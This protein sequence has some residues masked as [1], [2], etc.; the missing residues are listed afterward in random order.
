M[1]RN[2]ILLKAF[3]TFFILEMLVSTV[4]PTVSY[5]LTAGPTAPEAT[6]FEPVDTTDMVNLA[7]GDFV[8]NMPLLEVPGPGG[9][10]PLSL[11]YHAGIQPNEDASWV[12]LGWTL[13]PGAI[14]RGVNGYADDFDG[15]TGSVRTFWEG[16]ESKSYSI[17]INYG[18]AQN[19]SIS[20]GL[21]YSEDT[22]MG[23]SQT[24]YVKVGNVS[25][26]HTYTNVGNG[27]GSQS[28]TS[29]SGQIG[30]GMGMSMNVSVSGNG[31]STEVS[32]Y[33][34]P[35]SLINGFK[36]RIEGFRSQGIS[37]ATVASTMVNKVSGIGITS[38]Q[39]NSKESSVSI[40]SSGFNLTIPIKAF[41]INISSQL[42]R[43]WIDE[44]ETTQTH[45][46]LYF[47]KT[48]NPINLDERGYDIYDLQPADA[49]T[50]NTTPDEKVLGSF[51]DY[52]SYSVLGQGIGG[53]IKPYHY[54]AYLLRKNK[55]QSSS[56]SNYRVKSFPLG[57]NSAPVNFRFIGDFSNRFE[58]EHTNSSF[59]LSENLSFSFHNNI[60]TGQ[61][62]ID[63]FDESKNLL[64]GSK[65]V[66]WFTNNQINCEIPLVCPSSNGKP[67][68]KHG[69]LKVTALGFTRSQDNGIG[70]FL[71]KNASG[72]TYHYALPVYSYDEGSY[73]GRLDE[74]GRHYFNQFKRPHK[75]AYSWLLTAVTGPDY[76]DVN[77]NG[78][79]DDQDYGYWVVFDYGKWTDIYNWRNP[80]EGFNKDID[81]TF[82][83]FSKGKKE[84]YYLN[85]IRTKTH[86]A[87][88]VKE[89]RN[90]GKSVVPEISGVIETFFNH[91]VSD[92][93]D[94]GFDSKSKYLVSFRNLLGSVVRLYPYVEHP[95]STLK[96]S[97]IYLFRN[98]DIPDIQSY[99][100]QLASSNSRYQ[101]LDHARSSDPTLD[102]LYHQ[103]NNIIDIHDIS[104]VKSLLD[105]KALKK[106]EFNHDYSLV[107]NT[108]NS[109]VSSIDVLNST[110]QSS[111]FKTGKLTLK[112]VKF[113]TKG[114]ASLI[115]ETKFEY[116]SE[117]SFQGSLYTAGD[118][119]RN[120]SVSNFAL[121]DFFVGE[122][123][124]FKYNGSNIYAYITEIN[125]DSN[126]LKIKIIEGSGVPSHISKLVITKTK[127]PPY[128]K[129]FYDMWSM[130]KVDYEDLGNENASRM[131]T[132]VSRNSTDVWSMREITSPLG[133]TIQVEYEPDKYNNALKNLS[134]VP[135]KNMERISDTQ[136]RVTLFEN[137]LEY[138]LAQGDNI[139]L[140]FVTREK[141]N[142]TYCSINN[143]NCFSCNTILSHV[144]KWRYNSTPDVSVGLVEGKSF[145]IN[146]AFPYY[147]TLNFAG[148]KVS[149]FGISDL[150]LSSSY[151]IHVNVE[152]PIFVGG[153][154]LFNNRFFSPY[155]GD[156]RV[157]RIVHKTATENR[158]TKFDYFN[159][160]TTYEPTGFAVPISRIDFEN[161][162]DCVRDLETQA[163]NLYRENTFRDH[164][165]NRYLMLFHNARE[166]PGPGVLYGKVQVR[167]EIERDSQLIEIDGYKEY[168][169]EVFDPDL[170]NIN[171]NP[172]ANSIA[173]KF[174]YQVNMPTIESNPTYNG[175]NILGLDVD[176]IQIHSRSYIDD[177]SALFGYL[178][179]ATL[180]DKSG[181]KISETINEYL[182]EGGDFVAY[183]GKLAGYSNQGLIVESFADGRII[184][185]G[186]GE[187]T[188]GSKYTLTGIVSQKTYYPLISTGQTTINYKT[189]VTNKTRILAFDFYS[190]STVETLE[191]DGYGNSYVKKVVPA[192]TVY[193]PMGIGSFGGKNMLT[194]EAASYTFKVVPENPQQPIS[195][196]NYRP[197]GLVGASVQ[198]WSNQLPVVKPGENTSQ[199]LYQ[200]GIWRKH[201]S[202]SFA[203]DDN[204][205]LQA[206][207]LY[208][209]VNNQLPVFN[210]WQHDRYQVKDVP[211]NWQRNSEIT[212]YDVYSHALEAKDVNRLYAATKMSLDQT[213]VFATVA[214]AEYRE[215]AFSG[216]EEPAGQDG[217]VGGGV[218]IN[219]TKVPT[220]HTGK[221]GVSAATGLR[222]F[223]YYMVPRQRNYLVSVWASQPDVTIKYRLDNTGQPIT[224][225]VQKMGQASAWYLHQAVIPITEAHD[226]LE[227]WC[228]AKNATTVFDDFRVCPVDAAM[229]S[230]VYN[231]WGELSHIL[232]NN[233]LFTRYE[234]DGMGRLTRT[235]KETFIRQGNTPAYGNQGIVLVSEIN[236]NY[237]ANSTFTVPFEA[238]A[239]GMGNIYPSG[240]IQIKQGTDFNFSLQGSCPVAVQ[241]LYIDGLPINLAQAE[242][243]LYDGSKIKIT[244]TGNARLIAFKG[245]Q[246]GHKIHAVFN[247]A[248]QEQGGVAYC[249]TSTYNNGGQT[250]TCYTG[251]YVYRTL[252]DC[253]LLGPPV[254]V[255]DISQIPGYLQHLVSECQSN[256]PY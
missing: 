165:Y 125:P 245:I 150:P 147:T 205:I 86:T 151:P 124:R 75:Y 173:R 83:N 186:S 120:L 136:T 56:N 55:K 128:N 84:L 178:K 69:L 79:A 43:Y 72:V 7:T 54:R 168:E 73:S 225:T 226:N 99:V 6:S 105:G 36:D 219:G 48:Q 59:D 21:T 197:I 237:G 101:H 90:D 222:A 192:Y 200:T 248:N 23:V 247:S 176:K 202:Y 71:I 235:F 92:V 228:E 64:P 154:L 33:G 91:R 188:S 17:G 70:G 213:K 115:P 116:D 139:K 30:R 138:G 15:Q 158:I 63:G 185:N 78:L 32:K 52:D 223:T 51:V 183:K 12:G 49:V 246:G 144:Y 227:I 195:N 251:Y 252:D 13:N 163:I 206:D 117:Y 133:S 127:N 57:V 211:P 204:T 10:Y 231:E 180:F 104:N 181:N 18:D 11:S 214:N 162:P 190:G 77:L 203:G 191:I 209:L 94:G 137:V 46:S 39:Q 149:P 95:V 111:N 28:N 234:Y 26:Q 98:E 174:S 177:F 106:I 220:A 53:A 9:G 170:V 126:N 38:T 4:A 148:Q 108:A 217:L 253:G 1:F 29:I 68:W 88:F 74:K 14:N 5:A 160:V 131:T 175:P 189:G 62:G 215:F 31:L 250:I 207:G 34:D 58:Y 65:Q 171:G 241:Q 45:G 16:G 242:H 96:L 233:N 122:I 110:A 132:S 8:Y 254:V 156:I 47:P 42:K 24:A 212:L 146:F 145:I 230:Y 201:E 20:A 166:L 210:S 224:T 159:G 232:D 134:N 184:I 240:T 114:G 141:I 221:E 121:H 3:A 97:S 169:F 67:A 255:S 82:N 152:Q 37:L 196:T 87:I 236:Y 129:D 76:V 238:S 61:T 27:V 244:G 182:H 112:S 22:Y 80:S 19:P 123:L 103:G 107:P 60:R 243:T 208:P 85:S 130:Y 50:S 40:S 93:D 155:G 199:H 157:K 135:I 172:P 2:R 118:G 179:R 164:T 187:A 109:F 100:V 218:Y 66:E 143:G 167:D 81:N 113:Y 194:Q 198:T 161:V 229:T 119:S 140:S 216:A 256:C 35:E 89:I 142:S 249:Q 41:Q 193:S 153:E 44:T 239:A 102:I 25:L